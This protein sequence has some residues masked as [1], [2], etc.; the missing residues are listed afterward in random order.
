VVE[1][2]RSPGAKVQDGV[3]DGDWGRKTDLM[4]VVDDGRQV[5][6]QCGDPLGEAAVS[7]LGRAGEGV[8]G[9]PQTGQ[10]AGPE[11]THGR[12]PESG[13]AWTPCSTK[14]RAFKVRS[15]AV[16]SITPEPGRPL[17]MP[18]APQPGS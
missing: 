4:R 9:A 10:H 17:S 3:A 7:R 15:P 18:A 2:S 1:E 13:I 14:I 6:C 12:I 5:V 11:T 16:I 8:S